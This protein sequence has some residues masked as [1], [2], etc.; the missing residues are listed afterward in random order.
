MKVLEKYCMGKVGEAENED[1]L[2]VDD[3][4]IAVIDGATDKTGQKIEG[5]TGGLWISRTIARTM[6]NRDAIPAD[7][8][9]NDWISALTYHVAK[10]L[11]E[12]GWPEGTPN[13]CASVVV[14]SRC[15]R[16]IWRVGDC[17]FTI[18]NKAFPGGKIIDTINGSLRAN[19]IAAAIAKGVTIEGLR[20]DDIGNRFIRPL[21]KA[22]VAYENDP[23]HPYGFP[24]V[25]G[26]PVPESLLEP[27]FDVPEGSIC[28]MHSDG[29]DKVGN[30]VEETLALQR[31]SYEMDPLR[32]GLNGREPC[33]KAL[34]LDR[35]RH[36]DQT[37][38]FFTT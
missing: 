14:Y 36:D 7:I 12:A 34:P 23:T 37:V 17:S 24:V 26:H 8:R 16:E 32:I 35:G 30:T 3:D 10:G 29:F 20:A 38:V 1:T 9:M 31:A 27:P 6:G 33:V 4:F 18:G 5:V 19:L 22:Q 2:L 21:V 28:T 13:P 11:K 25:N 15:R